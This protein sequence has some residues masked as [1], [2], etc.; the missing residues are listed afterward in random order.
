LTVE[1]ILQNV[2][3]EELRAFVVKKAKFNSDLTKAIT[4]EFAE[5]LKESNYA[6]VENIYKPLVRADLQ[7]VELDL[8][9]DDRYDY[10]D[11]DAEVNLSI[12]D[13]WLDKAQTF[14]NQQKYDDALQVCKAVIES[15]AEW[16]NEPRDIDYELTD[17]IYS[18]YQDDSFELLT[19][20]A[21]NK[22]IN[23]KLL[24][25]YCKQELIKKEYSKDVRNLFSD[26]MAKLA[27][28]VNP[29]E[30]IAFQNN[31]LKQI[32]DKSS[33][34]AEKIVRRLYDFYL[35][36]NQKDK[37][38]ETVEQNIQIESFCKMVVEKRI[39]EKQYN[40]AKKLIFNFLKTHT[41]IRKNDWYEYLLKI[42]QKEKDIPTIRRIAFEFIEQNF[43]KQHFNIYKSAFSAEEWND[44]FEKLY[45][46]YDKKDK[47]WHNYYNSNIPDLLA[48]ENLTERLLEYI[49]SHLTAETM[50]KCSRFLCRKKCWRKVL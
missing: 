11:E 1:D 5:K 48:A 15:Y 37:A 26:L 23:K 22:Q 18:D 6:D 14:V 8:Y 21:Y 43:D 39:V 41:N 46:H 19:E 10:Y 28:S 13:E 29:E 50:E 35:S 38:E 25:E 49:N 47:S 24:Y 32:S 27:S 20:M 36:N 45:S 12:L 34:E 40:D 44:E 2:S 7:N 33:Y 3:L 31:L 4:L 42:A 9:S 17:Y 16:N 30:F